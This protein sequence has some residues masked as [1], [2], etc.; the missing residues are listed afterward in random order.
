MLVLGQ[1]AAVSFGD[2]LFGCYVLL[3]L[4][5]RHSVLLRRAVWGEHASI[6]RSLFVSIKEV[7][8]QPHKSH[9]LSE[10]LKK[11]IVCNRLHCFAL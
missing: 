7:S 10:G 9:G 6:L 5:Q 3:P 2:S 11:N 8:T 4:Q 1:Y